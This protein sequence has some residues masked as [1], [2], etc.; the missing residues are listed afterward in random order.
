M[1]SAPG[2]QDFIQARLPTGPARLEMRYHLGREANGDGLFA[3]S[4]LWPANW[5]EPFQLFI[6]QLA[7][8]RICGYPGVDGSLFV[9]G[10]NAEDP[11][12][13]RWDAHSA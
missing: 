11:P 9:L 13:L 3:G 12:V 8:I 10:R 7:G 2:F 1:A 6:G 4:R 5:T